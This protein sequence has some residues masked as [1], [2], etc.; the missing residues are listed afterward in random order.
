MLPSPSQVV[1]LFLCR[2]GERVALY[3]SPTGGEP[4]GHLL[5]PWARKRYDIESAATAAFREPEIIIGGAGC[6]QVAGC[7]VDVRNP[8]DWQACCKCGFMHVFHICCRHYLTLWTKSRKQTMVS[9]GW[10]SLMTI[11]C[12]AS[13]D[14]FFS[15]WVLVPAVYRVSPLLSP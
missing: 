1:R 4:Q 3:A 10:E 14:Y 8:G 7:A 9:S 5:C 2:L 12:A 6:G 13:L 15:S 11:E